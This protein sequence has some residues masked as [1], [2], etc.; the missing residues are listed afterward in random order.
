MSLGVSFALSRRQLS[1][2][3]SIKARR[4]AGV[5]LTYDEGLVYGLYAVRARR[6]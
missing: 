2:P 6:W 5:S 4:S 1:R 3:H